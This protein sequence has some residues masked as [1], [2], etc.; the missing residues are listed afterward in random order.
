MC[1]SQGQESRA[2]IE[3]PGDSDG[4]VQP[5]TATLLG[6]DGR[7]IVPNGPGESQQQPSHHQDH[8]NIHEHEELDRTLPVYHCASD[9]G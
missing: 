1:T 6:V 9:A 8:Q 3:P 4:Q 2:D 5:F 7:S